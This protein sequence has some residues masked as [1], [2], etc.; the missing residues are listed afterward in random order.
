MFTRL[1]L[2]L[3]LLV[4][5]TGCTQK[6]G[7]V[8]EGEPDTPY[9]TDTETWKETGPGLNALL[10]ST[11]KSF[12]RNTPPAVS[13]DSVLLKAWKGET[14]HA[15]LVVWS[16]DLNTPLKV[17]CKAPGKNATINPEI[18]IVRYVLSD[19][20]LNGC[21][22]RD[23]DTIPATI[24]PDRLENTQQFQ[25]NE[26][27]TRPVWLS[28][29]IPQ[30]CT[31][32]IYNFI[33][34]ITGESDTVELQLSIEVLDKT[35]PPPGE[36]HFHLDLWQNPY[37]VARYYDVQLWSQEHWDLLEPLLKK[38]ASAGQKCIS[39]TLN[40]KP[41]GGQTFDPF[42]SMIT[43]IKDDQGK[44]SYDYSVFDQYVNFAMDCG[45]TEQINCYTMVPWGNQFRYYSED[46]TAWVDIKAVPGSPEYIE[47]WKPFLI[48]F[49]EHLRDMGWIDIATIAM[50][51][52]KEEDMRKIIS[53]VREFAPELKITLAGNI[54][55]P[56]IDKDLYDLSIA[57][58]LDPGRDLVRQ[59]VE[60]GKPTTFYTC[61]SKPEH[62][63][64]FTFSPPADNTYIGWYAAAWGYSGFLRWAYNSWVENPAYDSRFRTWPS[65]DTYLVYPDNESSV[66]F[67]K[68]IEGIRD[69]EKIRI[70]KEEL[71]MDP[72]MKAAGLEK[73][74]EGFLNSLHYSRLKERP[75]AEFVT[76]G[77][78]LLYRIA[79]R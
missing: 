27:E 74:L 61:C 31:P 37:A 71:S 79:T 60:S 47:L 65:G 51:E 70:L 6:T 66:R 2:L 22:W 56:D 4:F 48:D 30:D 18:R 16:K 44:W 43:W 73:E 26:M 64:N 68:L 39:T 15:Q 57:L 62:P 23:K 63:N 12:Q 46:S 19:S 1:Q 35:L 72:S 20:F 40:D 24:S 17:E 52:R 32:G 50:D 7:N 75:S 38:L 34:T 42:G 21:G 28:F 14:V 69:F 54:L 78:N 76:E 8:P 41:W 3:I 49:R 55:Q 33:P 25:I 10:A 58:G 5:T 36:W 11:N 13:S 59:R 53:M 9:A 77:Q 45:I 67:E 29:S